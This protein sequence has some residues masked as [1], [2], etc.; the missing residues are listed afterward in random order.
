MKEKIERVRGKLIGHISSVENVNGCLKGGIDDYLV[1]FD[2]QLAQL[3][4]KL[5]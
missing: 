1:A 5:G 4:T 3:K 2:N